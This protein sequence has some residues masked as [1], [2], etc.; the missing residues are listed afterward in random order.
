MCFISIQM[1]FLLFHF[2]NSLFYLACD[3]LKGL[4]FDY[5]Y[6]RPIDALIA[7]IG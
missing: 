4:S 6:V 1:L 7:S 3:K 5:S 2:L